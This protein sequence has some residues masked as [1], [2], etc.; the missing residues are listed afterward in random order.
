MAAFLHLSRL[1]DVD[2]FWLRERRGVRK[3]R[4]VEGQKNRKLSAK[5]ITLREAP[6]TRK[7]ST[8]GCAASSLQLAP[9]TEPVKAM[10]LEQ[11]NDQSGEIS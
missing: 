9:L 8:S 10:N 3:S 2:E 7:P 1:Y 11:L 5:V 4:Q 6:P